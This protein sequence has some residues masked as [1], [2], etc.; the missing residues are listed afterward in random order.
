MAVRLPRDHVSKDKYYKEQERKNAC[1]CSPP[2]LNS[3]QEKRYEWRA[4]QY[5][6][7][8]LWPKQTGPQC[9]LVYLDQHMKKNASVAQRIDDVHP[10][11]EQ[12]NFDL[13]PDRVHTNQ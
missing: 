7:C 11:G 1:D 4:P 5:V 8:F 13:L 9:L 12:G 10:T 2:S 6:I 3:G